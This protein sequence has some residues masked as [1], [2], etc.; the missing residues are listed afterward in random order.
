M[1]KIASLVRSVLELDLLYETVFFGLILTYTSRLKLQVAMNVLV[2]IIGKMF[3]H[4]ESKTWFW[5]DCGAAAVR[6]GS[7]G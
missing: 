7:A 2:S 5:R 1:K 4:S 6:C 3:C